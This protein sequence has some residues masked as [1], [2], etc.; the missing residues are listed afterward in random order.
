MLRPTKVQ[1]GFKNYG[2]KKLELENQTLR[3]KLEDLE[4]SLQKIVKGSKNLN[5]AL[6]RKKN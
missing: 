3:S 1:R 2:I 4:T 6:G 5:M